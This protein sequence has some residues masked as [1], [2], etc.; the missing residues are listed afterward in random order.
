MRPKHCEAPVAEVKLLECKLIFNRVRFSKVVAGLVAVGLVAS[1][2]P[3]ASYAEGSSPDSVQMEGRA[4]IVLS[5]PQFSQERSILRPHRLP[6]DDE[7]ISCGGFQRSLEILR[8]RNLLAA[9]HYEEAIADYKE[10]LPRWEVAQY[11]RRWAEFEFAVACEM[12]GKIDDAIDHAKLAGADE[13]LARLYLKK[14]RYTRAQVLADDSIHR[15]RIVASARHYSQELACWL[16]LRAVAKYHLKKYEMAVADLKEAAQLYYR[17]DPA[18]ANTCAREANILIE[19]FKLGPPFRLDVAQLPAKGK[20]EVI[21]LVKYLVSAPEPFNIADLNRI[22]G[23]HIQLPGRTWCN[24]YKEEKAIRPFDGLEYCTEQEN[25]NA[26]KLFMLSITTDDCCIPKTEIDRLFPSNASKVPP[27]GFW[28][29]IYESP[30]AEA[31]AVPTGQL[32]LRVAAGDAHVLTDLEFRAVKS[33]EK[34]TVEQLVRQAERYGLQSEM[35]IGALTGAIRMD[36]RNPELLIERARAYC[37][38]GR[39]SEA[40]VDAK[41]A[42]ALGG[43]SYMDEQAVVEEKM[44]N[45]EAAIEHIKD[46]FD[47]RKTGSETA[48]GYARLAELYLENRQYKEALQATERALSDSLDKGAVLFVKAKAEAGLGNLP[49]ARSSAKAAADDYFSRAEIVLRDRVLDWLK[50]LP[51][52]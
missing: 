7:E 39:F 36:D 28:G 35:K 32:F 5:L 50:A 27:I 20:D 51:A 48:A 17:S 11:H 18:S 6:E 34:V 44:G 23:A 40:M 30:D 24:V 52:G 29:E 26:P 14:R 9:G 38:A 46:G 1:L 8:A 33:N 16:Q 41:R 3:L 25:Q 49:E 22:T 31:W 47:V 45:L 12:A 15:E 37:E 10:G 42:V 43:R 4:E 2:F 19:R 21:D 13:L